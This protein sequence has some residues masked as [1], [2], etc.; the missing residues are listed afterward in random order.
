MDKLEIRELTIKRLKEI[1]NEAECEVKA[2][3]DETK[4]GLTKWINMP[5]CLNYFENDEEY[6]RD[7]LESFLPEYKGNI[8]IQEH[9]HLN[10]DGTS[11][12]EEDSRDII[13]KSLN[14]VK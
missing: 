2:C 8:Y 3:K 14:F 6:L 9:K 10:N 13:I 4:K 12:V 5:V 7:Y 1:L 11:V